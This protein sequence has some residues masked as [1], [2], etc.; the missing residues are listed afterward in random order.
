MQQRHLTVLDRKADT[1]GPP[2]FQPTSNLPKIRL[3]LPDQWHSVWPAELNQFDVLANDP[4]VLSV[5]LQEPHFAGQTKEKLSSRQAAASG[6]P[7]ALR[8][9]NACQRQAL[10]LVAMRKE[11]KPGNN[12]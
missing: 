10:K 6:S 5:K 3:K 7:Q 9:R 12:D 2:P 1:R 8:S 11:V 4:P